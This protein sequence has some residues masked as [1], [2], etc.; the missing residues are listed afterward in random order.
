MIGKKNDKEVEYFYEFLYNSDCYESA[1]PTISVHRTLEGAENA[2]RKHK[3]KR[4]E[5]YEDDFKLTNEVN[6]GLGDKIL[7]RKEYEE[8]YP[9][10]AGEDW[11]V[12]PI[13]VLP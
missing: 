11:C 1:W 12:R 6:E 7:T 10:G 8:K 9:F 3:D 5:E 4:I 13:I 2:M